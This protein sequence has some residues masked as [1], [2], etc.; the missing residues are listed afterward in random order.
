MQRIY[1]IQLHVQF[2]LGQT[3]VYYVFM[4]FCVC[5]CVYMY[6]SE[7]IVYNLCAGGLGSDTAHQSVVHN[8]V[9]FRPQSPNCIWPPTDLTGSAWCTTVHC[10][11]LSILCR[12]VMLKDHFFQCNETTDAESQIQ[13]C[14][15]YLFS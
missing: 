6:I 15:F 14:T 1:N 8:G 13:L 4:C 11:L 5:I 9:Q 12:I 10:V 7:C 2:S 3:G